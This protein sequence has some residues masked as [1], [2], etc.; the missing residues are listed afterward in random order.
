M[1]KIQEAGAGA[2]PVAFPWQADPDFHDPDSETAA[3]L[4][5]ALRPV[6]DGASDWAGLI[7]ALGRRGVR[8]AIR[9]GRLVLTDGETGRRICTARLLGHPLADLAARLG[10]PCVL[11]RRDAPAAGEFLH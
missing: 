10:R 4:R 5:A 6:F 3:L 7:A 11:A 9:E 1:K 2:A 8:L